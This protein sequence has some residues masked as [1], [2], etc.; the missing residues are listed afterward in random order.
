MD[1]YFVRIRTDTWERLRDLQQAYDLDVFRPTARQLPDGVFQ[2]EGLLSEEQI[3]QLRGAGYEVEV[4]ADADVL[5]KER[6]E[7][8]ARHRRD[9]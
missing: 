1:T 2:I 6:R 9:L 7:E 8:L 5:A 4:T 3:G